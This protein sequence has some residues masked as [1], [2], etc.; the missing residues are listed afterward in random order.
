ME[1][2]SVIVDKVRFDK[3]PY[4]VHGRTKHYATT[5]EGVD[6]VFYM[7][8]ALE[9]GAN[10]VTLYYKPYTDDNGNEIEQKDKFG[11][12]QLKSPSTEP[13]KEAP[14]KSY[15]GGNRNYNK[16]NSYNQAQEKRL[17]YEK[18]VRDPRL[19]VQG[20]MSNYTQVYIAALREGKTPNDAEKICDLIYKKA[21]EDSEKLQKAFSEEKE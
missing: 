20:L 8:E 9:D 1:S 17:E 6:V 18:E 7:K 11:N 13:I 4:V 3:T 12:I 15:K 19:T 2:K 14:A 16:G 10:D 5:K 21:F